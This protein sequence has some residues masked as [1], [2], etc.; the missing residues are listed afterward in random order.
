MISLTGKQKS[1][2]RSL[3]MKEK[4]VFQIGKE[5]LTDALLLAIDAH[6][7]KNELM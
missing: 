6:I 4:S 7:R 3:A 2:L 1:Y 5:G